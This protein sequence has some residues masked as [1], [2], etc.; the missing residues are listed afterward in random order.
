MF[1]SECGKPAHGKFCSQCGAPLAITEAALDIIPS[2]SVPDWDREIHYETILKFPG[3]RDTIERHSQQARKRMTGEQYLA[4]ADKLVPMGVPLEGL[5]AL[6]QPLYARMGIKTGK[7][8][9]QQVRA[10]AG[11]VLVRALCSLAHH[12]QSLRGVTQAADGCLLNATLPSDLFSL[13][14]DLL[15]SV[16]RSGSEAEVSVATNISGQFFDWG[17][18]NRCLDQLFSDLE[19]DAA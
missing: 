7:V 19:H 13:E 11:R 12:G 8:R 1:C 4:L 15:V 6:V 5:A 17:K 10:P 14:G 18:S 9:A 2:E 3:V 16:R